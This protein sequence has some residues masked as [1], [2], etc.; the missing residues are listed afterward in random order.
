VLCRCLSVGLLITFYLCVQP[1]PVSAAAERANCAQPTSVYDGSPPW[2]QQRLNAKEVWPITDGAGV[3]VGVLSS[4]IDPRNA[5][6]D[7]GQVR[8]GADVSR[9]KVDGSA[10]VDCDGRG[11]FVA[12]LI[13]ARRVDETPLF[14]L[15][16]GV[17]LLPV[18]VAQTVAE[19]D[20]S[21]TE[22]RG[23][24]PDEIAFGIA[25]AASQGARVICVAV[26]SP[27][28]SPDLE[29]VVQRAVAAGVVIVAGAR[30]DDSA[31]SSAGSSEGQA[32][33]PAAYPDVIAVTALTE[34][35]QIVDGSEQGP[36]VDLAGPGGSI[37][38]TSAGTRGQVG[39][40]GPLDEPAAAT[41]YVAAAAALVLAH[42]PGLSPAE[43]QYRL[44]ATADHSSPGLVVAPIGAGMVD[45]YAAV[46][47]DLDSSVASL[48][49]GND[50]RTAQPYA[51]P[52]TVSAQERGVLRMA[53]LIALVMSLGVLGVLAAALGHRRGWR[54]GKSVAQVT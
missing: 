41:A 17:Q 28:S 15:A 25:Y 20:G 1:I 45:P 8:P 14:G 36:H 29:A 23:G 54:P 2:A 27:V 19:A 49:V 33:Y 40:V 47:T 34:D 37:W 5:Q 31:G 30:V 44:Q 39:H 38:S 50:G 13:G 10:I 51:A 7:A 43:V 11:T 3:T 18:R 6:L 52:P 53:A 26:A 12:G 32:S 21:S 16:P 46:T 24:G 42:R 22:I 9:G 48:V 4:G 35:G